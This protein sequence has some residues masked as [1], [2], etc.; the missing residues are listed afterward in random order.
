MD[1]AHVF[2]IFFDDKVECAQFSQ[3]ILCPLPATCYPLLRVEWRMNFY[4]KVKINR[5][6]ARKYIISHIPRQV[7]NVTKHNSLDTDI[8]II[9][10]RDIF[11]RKPTWRAIKSL[12]RTILNALTRRPFLEVFIYQYSQSWAIWFVKA[13]SSS[14]KLNASF[15][16]RWN[17]QI[18][19][20]PLWNVAIN[21]FQ[22]SALPTMNLFIQEIGFVGTLIPTTSIQIHRS[23][24]RKSLWQ[25]NGKSVTL[26]N[27]W[28]QRKALGS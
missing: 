15:D 28:R 22:S 1:L 24:S 14:I 7:E 26:R 2:N 27:F 23:R 25:S 9:S 20:W 4:Q 6:L 19:S 5:E 12:E 8:T 11:L 17:T 13:S 10:N 18:F 16:L 21:I 3:Q